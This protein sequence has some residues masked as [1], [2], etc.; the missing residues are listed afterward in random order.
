MMPLYR[1]LFEDDIPVKEDE[2]DGVE[3]NVLGSANGTLL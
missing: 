2:T 1:K 3:S